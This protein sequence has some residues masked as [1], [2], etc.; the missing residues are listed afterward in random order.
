MVES[1]NDLHDLTNNEGEHLLV[2]EWEMNVTDRNVT[3]FLRMS[4]IDV[5]YLFYIR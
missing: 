4:Q 1:N 3:D 5:S 2:N